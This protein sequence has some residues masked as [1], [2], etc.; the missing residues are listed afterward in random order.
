MAATHLRFTSPGLLL[1]F[2][3]AAWPAPTSAQVKVPSAPPRPAPAPGG[4][5]D[6]K[7][8]EARR[9]FEQGV[10]L[11]GEGNYLGALAE[12]QAAYDTTPASP[13]LFNI[14]LT[15]KAL[16]R[17]TEAIDTLQRYLVDGVKDGK[18]TPERFAQVRQLIEEMKSLL[19]PVTFALSP[20]TARLVVDGRPTTVPP[21]GVVPLAAGSHVVDVS[22]EDHE[23]QRRQFS[24]AAGVALKQEFKLTRIVRT[25]KVRVTSSQPNTRVVIDGKDRGFAPLELELGAGGHQLDARADG[26]ETLRTELMLA[27]GQERNVDLELRRPPPSERPV[28]KRWWFWTG[29]GTAVAGGTVAAF[30][31]RPGTEAPLSGGLD[32]VDVTK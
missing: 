14:G 4:A 25:G 8:D 6:F 27:A 31:L 17:Y 29:L 10:A 32:T 1:A 11:Y 3:L 2:T 5:S 21:D 23:P 18:L 9:H 28:Y 13:T 26:F 15:Q 16:F 12:F 24:V 19:A 7:R 20:P 30:M 22:A